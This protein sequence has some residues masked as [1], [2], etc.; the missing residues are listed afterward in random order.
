MITVLLNVLIV[1][2]AFFGMEGVAW[3]SHKYIMH[4]IG[5]F[6]HKD[7]HKKESNGFFELNDFFFLI[8]AFPGITLMY[9]GMKGNFNYFFWVG[10]GISLYGFAYIMV[11]DILVHQRFRFLR[12]VDSFYLKAIRRRHKMHHKHIGRKDGK[13]F[14]I[15]WVPMK[16]FKDEL[17]KQNA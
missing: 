2:S 15:L 11:H 10:L 1:F 12:K 6:L 8:F 17:K 3:L 4:G 5:W 14:G 16:Y 9:I 13:L 7:H